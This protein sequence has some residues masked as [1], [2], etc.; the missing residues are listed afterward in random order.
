MKEDEERVLVLV[1]VVV[2]V[3]RV[4]RV[5]V[6]R[7]P[8]ASATASACLRSITSQATPPPSFYLTMARRGCASG[9]FV[10]GVCEAATKGNLERRRGV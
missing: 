6:L 10:G 7:K 8:S 2:L 9:D 5:C 4:V 1:V 3:V